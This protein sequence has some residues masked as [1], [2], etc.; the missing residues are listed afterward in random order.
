MITVLTASMPER[1]ELLAEAIRSVKDQTV[2][3]LAHL[4]G[5]DIAKRNAPLVYNDLAKAATTQWITFL[6]DDDLLDSDHLERL[7][8]E[9]GPD[10]DVVYSGCRSEG[11]YNYTYYNEPF[12]KDRLND[13]SI[14]PITALVRRRVFNRVGG[15]RDES[16]YDWHLWRRI[17]DVGGRFKQVNKITWTYR[18]HDLGNQSW[19]YRNRAESA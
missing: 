2:Q 10:V 7:S 14:I 19:E 17:A 12:N 3:P 8:K 5:I 13:R 11:F 16:G 6:D 15:F 9:A 1:S 18:F 4:V